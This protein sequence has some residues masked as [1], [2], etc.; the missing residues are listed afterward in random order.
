MRPFFKTL[1]AQN[2]ERILKATK[3]KDKVTYKGRPINLE[4]GEE[5][6]EVHHVFTTYGVLGK[7]GFS[8][9]PVWENK[10]KEKAGFS[11]LYVVISLLVVSSIEKLQTSDIAFTHMLRSMCFL[12]FIPPTSIFYWFHLLCFMWTFLV[13][14]LNIDLLLV[15]GKWTVGK[16]MMEVV[17]E[18]QTWEVCVSSEGRLLSDFPGALG[19]VNLCLG[20]LW[21]CGELI[22]FC[23][24]FLSPWDNKTAPATNFLWSHHVGQSGRMGC[25]QNSSGSHF[26]TTL[27][28]PPL[29]QEP[30]GSAATIRMLD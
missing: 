20:F 14:C 23:L 25:I 7:S 11:S 16:T 21:S 24:H 4:G 19:S 17:S 10:T 9:D 28:G 18:I 13:N 27:C 5:G 29:N 2:K 22:S 8:W 1:K 26:L 3:K 12:D 30:V 15:W 6:S